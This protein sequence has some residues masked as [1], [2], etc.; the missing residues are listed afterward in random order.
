MPR[1][2]DYLRKPALADSG[3]I[4]RIERL[5]ER[6]ARE[7]PL[8]DSEQSTAF[9]AYGHQGSRWSVYAANARDL[10]LDGFA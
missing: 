4:A 9:I 10:G 7:E 1:D 2:R 8:F 6:A 5:A 3:R